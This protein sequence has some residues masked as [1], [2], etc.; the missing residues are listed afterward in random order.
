[1]ETENYPTLIDLDDTTLT[2]ANPLEDIRGEKVYDREGH[3]IG[4]VD[5]LLVDE[6]EN[7]VRFLRI[8]S[9]GF[10]GLGK[11]KRLIPVDAITRR[12]AGEVHIDRTKDNVAGSSPY[13]PELENAPEY[14]AGLYGYYGYMPFWAPGYAP[15]GRW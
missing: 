4:N 11:T 13:D 3:E 1:M 5:G 2:L 12:E 6:Q 9:G 10:L 15:R 7:R 14:Y 8:G